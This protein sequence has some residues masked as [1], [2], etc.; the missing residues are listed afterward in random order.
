MKTKNIILK[1]IVIVFAFMNFKNQSDFEKYKKLQIK[2]VPSIKPGDLPNEFCDNAFNIVDEFIRKTSGCD[3]EI[4]IY[5]DYFSG[6]II[7]CVIGDFDNVSF[8]VNGDDRIRKNICSIH[9]H[10]KEVFS[11]PSGKNFGILM[12]E[13]EDYELIASESE[14]WILKA[15]G[16][17]ERLNIDLKKLE[18]V[19]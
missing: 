13:Y 10:P 4:L 5:F 19:K 18:K 9:N 7:E 16:V 3:K 17:N 14:L 8:E 6:E 11:P 12:R 1:I 2:D 15:K